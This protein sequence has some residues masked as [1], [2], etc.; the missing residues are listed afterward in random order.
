M[1]DSSAF[2]SFLSYNRDTSCSH[3]TEA[4]GLILDSWN[5][6]RAATRGVADSFSE[7]FSE[8]ENIVDIRSRQFSNFYSMACIVIA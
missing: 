2:K 5:L 7:L 6:K 4:D 8:D 3:R 1:Q